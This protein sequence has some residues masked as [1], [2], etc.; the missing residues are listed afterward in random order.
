MV[1]FYYISIAFMDDYY[2]YEW[3]SLCVQWNSVEQLF[4]LQYYLKVPIVTT[5][6]K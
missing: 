1:D 2:I 6:R 3:Y 4:W 5:P